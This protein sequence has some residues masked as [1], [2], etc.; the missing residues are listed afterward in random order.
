MPIYKM[1]ELLGENVRSEPLNDHEKTLRYV[2]LLVNYAS[3]VFT[4]FS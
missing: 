4:T 2:K 1:N 3:Q